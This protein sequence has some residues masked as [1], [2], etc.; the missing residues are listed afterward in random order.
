M[1]CSCEGVDPQAT[2][3]DQTTES[4][5]SVQTGDGIRP[6][7]THILT[8]FDIKA[9]LNCMQMYSYLF[10]VDLMTSGSGA[11][12]LG[13]AAAISTAACSSPS[14]A[15]FSLPH[16]LVARLQHLL[17]PVVVIAHMLHVCLHMR[18]NVYAY[19]CVC[20]C[21]L[22]VQLI[23]APETH[24]HARKHAHKRIHALAQWLPPPPAA[25]MRHR[26]APM[27]SGA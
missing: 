16:R 20:M 25:C 7:C 17:A 22:V 1:A 23:A 2:R 8:T 24:L 9:T 5:V 19:V 13:G 26:S 27:P 6:S 3:Y 11:G 12:G 4:L 18:V 14:P 15:P 10:D 21:S